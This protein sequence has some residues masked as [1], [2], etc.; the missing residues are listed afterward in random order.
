MT[1][2]RREHLVMYGHPAEEDDLPW[3]WVEQQLSDAGT[4]W[5]TAS[6]A[7]S[8]PH[9]RPVWGVWV[10]DCVCLSVGSPALRA[11]LPLGARATVHLDSGTEVVIVEGTVLAARDDASLI[12]R[13]DSKYDWTY[14]V[15]RYGPLLPVRAVKVMAWRTAGWAG[16]DGFGQTGRWQLGD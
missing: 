3:E 16:R 15:A 7:T 11:Q 9:P 8:W 10:D 4:Y 5:V 6:V 14:D 12:G 2:P 1:Q 13:Y